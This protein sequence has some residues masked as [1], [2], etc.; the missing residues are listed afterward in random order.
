MYLC[1]GGIAPEDLVPTGRITALMDTRRMSRF[2]RAF[3]QSTGCV[4]VSCAQ[5]G[6]LREYALAE[7]YASENSGLGFW[8]V[9]QVC[10]VSAH[11]SSPAASRRSRSAIR[12]RPGGRLTGAVP[13]PTSFSR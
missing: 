1:R 10:S 2:C 7:Q 12:S 5:P 8:V 4:E 6:N 3:D 9:G 13:V 11:R